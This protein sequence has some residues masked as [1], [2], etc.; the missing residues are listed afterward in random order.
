MTGNRSQASGF[1]DGTPRLGQSPPGTI[2]P[3]VS[4]RAS[5]SHAINSNAAGLPS[6]SLQLQSKPAADLQKSVASHEM[7]DKTKPILSASVTSPLP[8]GTPHD[9]HFQ[10]ASYPPQHPPWMSTNPIAHHPYSHHPAVPRDMYSVLPSAHHYGTVPHY[11]A[12]DTTLPMH[13]Q[14]HKEQVVRSHPQA[15]EQ[16]FTRNSPCDQVVPST[17][18][19]VIEG[20]AAA[21]PPPSEKL[22]PRIDNE[23]RRSVSGAHD[24]RQSEPVAAL[25][26][27]YSA[28][29]QSPKLASSIPET[30]DVDQ[31]N[32]TSMPVVSGL[33]QN[34]TN[35]PSGEVRNEPPP[36]LSDRKSPRPAYGHAQPT[37]TPHDTR[38]P[39]AFAPAFVY[40][41]TPH[42][43]A[44]HPWQ[45]P[46][47][48][49]GQMPYGQIP[50][51]QIPYYSPYGP[52][53]HPSGT[54]PNHPHFHPDLCH[55]APMAGDS[56]SIDV[57][58][59]LSLNSPGE[60]A[61]GQ[62][63]CHQ[64]SRYVGR[65]STV[66]TLG[67]Q[68]PDQR[69][70]PC[71]AADLDEQ[72]KACAHVPLH[73]HAVPPQYSHQIRHNPP[74]APVY[75]QYVYPPP[76]YPDPRHWSYAPVAQP[77]DNTIP[78]QYRSTDMSGDDTKTTSTPS[79]VR[80]GIQKDK[81]GTSPA[82]TASTAR[83]RR[84]QWT[85]TLHARFEKA[86]NE[87]GLDVAV[88]KA[89]LQRMGVHGLSRENVASHLQ[90]YREALKKRENDNFSKVAGA[91]NLRAECQVVD[92]A[93][94][95]GDTQTMV[96]D[97]HRTQSTQ[98]QAS[99]PH[100]GTTELI[101]NPKDPCE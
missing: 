75:G 56:R 82:I 87:I 24:E 99:V 66:S 16:V 8:G 39:A 85:P 86:V 26:K 38:V 42:P 9:V 68:V 101:R 15:T 31:R 63:V 20:E 35:E 11:S 100:D 83:R 37:S 12:V 90:K 51:S 43:P 13:V 41:S 96:D 81:S 73:V 94:E 60:A 49:Y 30:C 79:T 61:N 36:S 6:T 34:C 58:R 55:R 95:K 72:Q 32:E 5:A 57:T 18:P 45:F 97:S 71:Y 19:G 22:H 47:M 23:A 14:A 62:D 84:L 78:E 91:Q 65:E 98:T 27:G 1:L 17:I 53:V 54:I 28:A 67:A 89:I 25:D 3:A 77:P 40:H 44:F 29:I 70:V 10:H 59:A 88:P 76:F 69:T 92:S 74:L 80:A 7:P 64:E 2:R 93:Q 52:Y 33:T 4:A 48:P 46:Q 50:Y 21:P